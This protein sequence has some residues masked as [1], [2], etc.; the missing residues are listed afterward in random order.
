MSTGTVQGAPV[1]ELVFPVWTIDVHTSA[2]GPV[3][4]GYGGPGG[5]GA[6]KYWY[7]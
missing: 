6:V 4:A 7:R 2:A 5:S 3:I 1:V